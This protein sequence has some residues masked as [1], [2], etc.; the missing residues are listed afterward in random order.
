LQ[1]KLDRNTT[2]FTQNPY[3]KYSIHHTDARKYTVHA[4]SELNKETTRPAQ[5]L[6]AGISTVYQMKEGVQCAW[7]TSTPTQCNASA[8]YLSLMQ[9]PEK[10]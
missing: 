4:A 7:N 3:Q 8:D 2:I 1:R 10:A 6:F 5:H 9:A